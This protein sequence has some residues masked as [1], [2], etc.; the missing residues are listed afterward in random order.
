M[1]SNTTNNT[2]TNTTND[3]NDN[4]HT[5]TETN[6]ANVNPTHRNGDSTSTAEEMNLARLCGSYR[7]K[8]GYCNG[9]RVN[10]LNRH[11]QELHS[12]RNSCTEEEGICNNSH[13]HC[14]KSSH[15]HDDRDNHDDDDDNNIE[16]EEE[17]EEGMI[18]DSNNSSKCYGVLFDALTAQD[19][20]ILLNHGWRRSGKHLYLP[21][22]WKSCCPAIPIRLH[23]PDFNPSKSQKRVLRRMRQYLEGNMSF[24]VHLKKEKS[25]SSGAESVVAAAT[26]TKMKY[27]IQQSLKV[28]LQKQMVTLLLEILCKLDNDHSTNSLMDN[29]SISSTINPE[30][31]NS[32][33]TFQHRQTKSKEKGRRRKTGE[34]VE[35]QY[36]TS[37]VCNA[38]VGR[39]K[40]SG[41][42]T[43]NDLCR[44]LCEK[45]NNAILSL[46]DSND[47]NRSS[48]VT[49]DVISVQ[50]VPKT[51]HVKIGIATSA[52]TV[53]QGSR[54]KK[55]ETDHYQKPPN[56]RNEQQ[57]QQS[58]VDFENG[59]NKKQRQDDNT[60]KISNIPCAGKKKNRLIVRSIPSYIS[61]QMPEVHKLYAKYQSRVHGDRNPYENDN[62]EDSSDESS[63]EE[64]G[65]DGAKG[66]RLAKSKRSFERFLCESPIPYSPI[67]TPI[68]PS[69]YNYDDGINNTNVFTEEE[70]EFDV[71]IPYGSYHQQYRLNGELIAVGVVDILPECLSSVYSFYDPDISEVINLGKYTALHEIEWVRQANERRSTGGRSTLCYYYLGYYIHSCTKMKYKAEYK[72]SKLLCPVSQ[73][74]VDYEIAMK[75][76]FNNSFDEHH[77]G[78]LEN[79]NADSKD[80]KK[81]DYIQCQQIKRDNIYQ[82]KRVLEHIHLDIGPQPAKGGRR[83]SNNNG[84]V[85]APV[86]TLGMLTAYGR[87]ML[88]PL[89]LQFVNHVGIEVAQRCKIK[90]Q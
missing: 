22:N 27:D 5:N 52:L 74:W 49:V 10:I 28:E 72:P 73:R 46:S 80:K 79:Y 32:L 18:M 60:V 30:A 15:H 69:K 33:C 3:T 35:V 19:Y 20:Q 7:S 4:N 34:E 56:C 88:D 84:K 86:V 68:S 53:M 59:T 43:A 12:I 64:D 11:L 63:L 67:P 17:E 62:E 47:N 44:E 51:G 36:F 45:M 42:I 81:R 21:D 70:I 57:M 76:A 40:L 90:L 71:D 61:G 38:L 82:S 78:S 6:N 89:L 26:A 58:V 65:K 75:V 87:A 77:Y 54:N 83:G 16:E 29:V 25:T 24:Q 8:C 23:V 41:V 39:Y 2:N 1:N 48:M 14:N 50:S 37:S 9:S 31:I 85:V 13:N 66:G 55:S